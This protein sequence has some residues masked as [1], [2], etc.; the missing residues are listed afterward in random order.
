MGFGVGTV[1]Q[2]V[3]FVGGCE[4]GIIVPNKKCIPGTPFLVQSIDGYRGAQSLASKPKIGGLEISKILGFLE[5]QIHGF[6]WALGSAK[7]LK[8]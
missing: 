7:C 6:E 4:P 1:S 2:K 8:K 3:T 5:H